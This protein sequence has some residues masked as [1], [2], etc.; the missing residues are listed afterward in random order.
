M[1]DVPVTEQ[2]QQPSTRQY[3]NRWLIL[4]ITALAAVNLRT[5]LVGFSPVL[6][7]VKD[8]LDLSYSLS[9]FIVG[10]PVFFT[11]IFGAVGGYL[12][13]VRGGKSLVAWGLL[14]ITLGNLGRGF[15][16]EAL[17]LLL[18]SIVFGVGL[19]LTQSAMPYLTKQIFPDMPG[20][21]TG[22]YTG[23]MLTGTL[24][25]AAI[26]VPVILPLMG[27]L[28]WRGTLFVWTAVAFV[29][30]ILWLLIVPHVPMVDKPPT[31][32]EWTK[33]WR[34]W[35]T[36]HV[37]LLFCLQSVIFNSYIA[38]IPTFYYESG[39]DPTGVFTF[40]NLISLPV[41]LLLPALSDR[42]GSRRTLLIA[43][44]A[45]CLVGAVMHV[46]FYDVWYYVWAGML[47][48]AIT[49]VFA[50]SLVLAVDM[51]SKDEV[52]SVT[53]LVLL[54]GYVGA[55][56]ATPFIGWLRDLS[57]EFTFGLLLVWTSVSL[58]MIVLSWILPARVGM[59]LQNATS[60]R[61]RIND[62]KVGM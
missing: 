46:I 61:D 50:L 62:G 38:W 55:T 31:L 15:A 7:L 58:V 48:I 19:G 10:S 4:L 13:T 33:T 44:S 57:G 5:G 41:T 56:S 36:W 18:A 49:A 60:S 20:T 47:G 42:I 14:F 28:S 37:A 2:L 39:I 26:T 34:K 24:T 6:P 43:A 9:G 45:L 17:I 25:G 11:G 23:G 21:A 35:K 16:P 29:S 8:E 40:Y 30:L 12:V 54:F 59:S 32:R 22:A 53:G 27:D 3:S 51:S 1:N 52:G